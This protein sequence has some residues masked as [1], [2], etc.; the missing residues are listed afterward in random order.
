MVV[1]F[2]L[3]RM[4]QEYL[5]AASGCHP[6]PY[7]ATITKM[8]LSKDEAIH[9]PKEIK[10]RDGYIIQAI[11]LHVKLVG[12]DLSEFQILNRMLPYFEEPPK[13]QSNH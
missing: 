7:P 3:V 6:P 11:T 13:Q 8:D 4:L 5:G 9:K 10:T 1:S 2:K 12:I